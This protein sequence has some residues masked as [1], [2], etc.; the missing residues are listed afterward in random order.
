MRFDGIDGPAKHGLGVIQFA[1]APRPLR[2]LTGKHHRHAAPAIDD[3]VDGRRIVHKGLERLDQF[4]LA[5]DRKRRAHGE[6]RAA[7][8]E[9][10]G[11]R[12]EIEFLPG[13][14]V[15]QPPRALGECAGGAGRQRDHDPGLRGQRHRPGPWPRRTVLADHTV[16]IGAAEAERIDSHDHRALGKRLAAGLHL[17]GTAV[18]IDRRIGHH[19]V[20]GDRRECPPLQ[21][22][23]DLE[24]RT[25]ERRGFHVPHVALDAGNPQRGLPLGSG[26]RVRDGVAF[27]PIPHDRAGGMGFDVVEF[28]W[29]ATGT[30]SRYPHQLGL[31]MTGGRRDVAPRCQALAPVGSAGRID[32][33]SLDDSVDGVPITLG[34][35]Q[36]LDGEDERPLGTHVAVGFRVEGM[37]LP[38][39]ADDFQG[40]EGGAQ[41]GG[42]QVIDRTDQRLLAVAALEAVHGRMERREARRTRRAVGCRGPHQVEVVGDAVGEHGQ[43][44]ARHV[45]RLGAP[46]RPPVRDGR[47]LGP[48]EDTRRTVAQ[49]MKIP[50]DVLERLPGA[51]QQHPHLRIRRQHFA[52]GQAEETAIEQLL[53]VVADEAFVGAGKPTRSGKAAD[54]PVTSPVAIGYGFL[55]DLALAQQIPEVGVGVDAARQSVAVPGNGNRKVEFL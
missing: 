16:P 52:L 27:D 25:V 12:V 47:H 15:S 45:E 41:P 5:P 20:L 1:T 3:R 22:H 11:Q 21:H 34:R 40:V 55:N 39:G 31:G 9:I 35:R 36:R 19:E 10:A 42:S 51:C 14:E 7:A 4:L 18:E 17:H 29:P 2:A 6:M 46:H 30:G 24:Q 26:K 32:G 54:R 49:R 53:L 48:D 37:A 33:G 23:E 50:A 13:E 44:D 43:A 28:L 8:A 38:V